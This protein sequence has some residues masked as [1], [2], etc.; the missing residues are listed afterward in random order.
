MDDLD[1]PPDVDVQLLVECSLA[2][3]LELLAG[4]GG[5]REDPIELSST[6]L[7]DLSS[8]SMSSFLPASVGHSVLGSET[9]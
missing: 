8:A 7:D 9:A 5:A 6:F 4:G 3:F 2:D 1:E